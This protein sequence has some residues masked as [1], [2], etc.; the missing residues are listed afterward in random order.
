MPRRK[1][2]VT[3]HLENIS[4]EALEQYLG[5]CGSPL[6]GANALRPPDGLPGTG[7]AVSV[8]YKAARLVK[9]N[10]AWFVHP[11]SV[12]RFAPDSQ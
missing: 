2:Q 12:F 6:Q 7:A 1:P 10:L 4:R 3:K 9:V 8:I 5:P 11:S